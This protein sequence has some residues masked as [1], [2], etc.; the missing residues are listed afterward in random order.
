M[1]S[2]PATSPSSPPAF[3]ANDPE[4]IPKMLQTKVVQ[5]FENADIDHTPLRA[6]DGLEADYQLVIDVRN[7]QVK[8]DPDTMAEIGLSARILAKE[9]HVV[10]PAYSRGAERSKRSILPRRSRLSTTRS[11]VSQLS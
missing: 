3:L 10:D 6:M 1:R 9:R 8:S 4:S 7:F 2:S 5:G 11:R